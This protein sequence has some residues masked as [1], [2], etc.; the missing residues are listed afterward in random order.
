MGQ[1][2]R[3]TDA[4]LAQIEFEALSTTPGGEFA[5]IIGDLLKLLGGGGPLGIAGGVSSLLLKIR[6]LAGASYA[7]N[8]IY[9]IT[10]V[11]NDLATL[12]DRYE[13]LRGRIEALPFDPVFAEAISALALRAMHT[14]VKN[15]LA[16][17][18]RIVV[19]GVKEGDLEPEGLDDM[20]R[21]AAELK[22]ADIVLLGRIY[23][24]Q[25]SILK[26]PSL[27]P[28]NWFQLI[29]NRWNEFVDS[30]ALDPSRHL[31]YRSSFS[32]LESHGLIQKFREISTAAVGLEHYALLEEGKKFYERLQ[33]IAV[34]Q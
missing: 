16:R 21:A 24:S 14:S 9:T 26:Q 25:R 13:S 3:E 29:Q 12:Y 2:E 31:A 18:A 30:G 1:F 8:L 23:D 32:R 27:S 28:T 34:Q 17:L 33:E 7:S 11:R 10:A 6:K 22:D 4:A 19:N 5:E 15:R 20:M